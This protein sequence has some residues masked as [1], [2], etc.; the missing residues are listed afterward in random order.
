MS[1]PELFWSHFLI[2]N[3]Q[4]EGMFSAARYMKAGHLTISQHSII[5]IYLSLIQPILHMVVS[6]IIHEPHIKAFMR[7]LQSLIKL[8]LF[9]TSLISV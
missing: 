6:I 7:I 2:L 5:H 4:K 8:L 3:I 1:G 9:V